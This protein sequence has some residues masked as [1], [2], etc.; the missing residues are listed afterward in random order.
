MKFEDYILSKPAAK[1]D[2]PFGEDVAVYKVADKMFALMPQNKSPVNISLKCDPA[3]S[4]LL[5]EKYE[6]VMPGYHLNKRHWIT[7]IDT[8]QL[9]QQ[10]IYDLIDHSY[11]LV[12]ESLPKAEQDRINNS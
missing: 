2:F 10:E 3:L 5:R 8:G 1:L 4:E 6:S 7:V 9:E 12:V 11:R